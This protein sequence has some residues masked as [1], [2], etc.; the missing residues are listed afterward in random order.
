MSDLYEFNMYLF[1]HGNTEEFL[2]FIRNFNMNLAATG[3]LDMDENI[4]YLCTLV[5]GEALRQ[6]DLLSADLENT[7]TLNLDY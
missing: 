6:F 1:D 3:T 5:L 2:L 7:E 4:Q